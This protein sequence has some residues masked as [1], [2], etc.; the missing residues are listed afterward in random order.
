MIQFDRRPGYLLRVV[1]LALHILAAAAAVGDLTPADRKRSLDIVWDTVNRTHFDP[2]FGGVDWKSVKTR[3]TARMAQVK[4]DRE[5]YSLLNEMLGELKQSHFAILP[6]ESFAMTDAAGHAAGSGE[7]GIT[8][9]VVEDMCVVTKVRE[10]SPAAEAGLRPGDQLTAIDGK[11]IDAV[12]KRVRLRKMPQAEEHAIIALIAR[13]MLTG[14]PGSEMTLTI[15]NSEDQE[16]KVV[17]RPVE[18]AS[19]REAL[20]GFPPMTVEFEQRRLQNNIGY[21]RFTPFTGLT[22]DEIRS[23]A[24]ALAD[25]PGVVI[26]LRGNPGG[27]LPVTYGIAGLFC[28]KPGTLGAMQMRTAKLQFTITPQEPRFKG[29]L[30]LLTDELSMSCSEVL[31]GGLQALSRGYVIGRQTPGMALPSTTAPL[32]GGARLQYAF[33]D[34]RT[35]RGTLI[36]GAGVRPDQAVTL[37]RRSL[38]AEGDPDLRA[39]VEYITAHSGQKAA[40]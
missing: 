31:A 25:A 28:D 40:R 21:I 14:K 4:S 5:T 10:K 38:Y 32:P 17:L 39:A 37:T 13:A 6:P 11:P 19:K 24:I 7:T 29:P 35:S 1:F 15:R 18:G 16:K 3:Y 9:G 27:L 36:E 26:D 30:V 12:M 23:A 2:T 33:A 20:P 34:F 8:V 22:M